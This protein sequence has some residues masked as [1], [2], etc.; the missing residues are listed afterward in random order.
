[1]ILRRLLLGG[2]VMLAACSA[3]ETPTPSV[4][5]ITATKDGATLYQENCASCHEGG[6]P[7]APHS[8]TF[9]MSPASSIMTAMNG[10]MSQQSEHLSDEEKVV[11]AEFLSGQKLGAS[12]TAAPV[13]MCEAGSSDFDASKP[14]RSV[15]WGITQE[16]TRHVAAGDAGLSAEDVPHLKLKW[17][18]SYADATR[19][20]SQPTIGGGAVFI[21]SQDGTIYALDEDTGCARWTYQAESE[22][23]SALTLDG[24]KS[25]QPTLFFGDFNANAYAID[26]TTGALIWKV[27]V[28][29]HEAATITG[30]P[31]LYKDTLY[32][33]V[34]SREWASAADP[35]YECCTFR[36]NVV[37]LNKADGTMQW[38]GHVVPDEPVKTDRSNA[39]G[40]PIWNP[41]GAPVWNSPTA[42]TRRGRLYM[43]T[44]EAYTSP[45]VNTSDAIVA[46]DMEN[47]ELIWAYQGTEGDAWNM[48]CVIE[49]K[50]NCPEENGPDFDFGAPPVMI[51]TAEGQDILLAGQ[52]SGMVHALD[53]ETGALLWK[54]RIGLGGFAG[55]VHWGMASDGKLL[56]APNAD[57]DFY[58]HWEGE[59]KPGMYGIEPTTGE[60]VWFTPAPDTCPEGTKPAC[61]PGLSAA[62]TSMV[63]VVFAGGFDGVLRA[64]DSTDGTVIW[65][66]NTVQDYETV[67]GDIAR[68]GTIESDGPVIANGKVFVNSGYLYGGRMAGNVLLVYSKDGK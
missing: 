9:N 29:D 46:M 11:L 45:A 27:A 34:S 35:E 68:G 56:Y 1:M 50:T 4:E 8:V 24:V 14:R 37:A 41:A 5:T 61:D 55:G 63:G 30:S 44:G 6:V 3:E 23:R 20:R 25:E 39:V 57:T 12:S 48:A 60:F 19:A 38:R 18:F 13:L 31:K 52:K 36:G 40:I 62:P 15:A 28:G 66:V 43:G 10:V 16:N 51:T 47:G 32:V 58:G 22:V 59:R 33:P 42:D 54:K 2:M 49:D 7:K 65:E 26:A 53:A 64:Y 21:G 67:N 17:A